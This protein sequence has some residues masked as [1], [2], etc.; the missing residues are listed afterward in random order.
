[1]YIFILII[2]E[3]KFGVKK[4]KK[5]EDFCFSVSLYIIAGEKVSMLLPLYFMGSRQGGE[6]LWIK[7]CQRLTGSL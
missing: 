7:K 4:I 1:M 2:S 3:R 6:V 5:L